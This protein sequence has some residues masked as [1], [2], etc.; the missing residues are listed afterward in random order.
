MAGILGVTGISD[1]MALEQ[2]NQAT[3][4]GGEM[5]RNTFLKLLTTQLQNQDPTSPMDNQEFVAQLAQ[6]TS[7]EQ[8][9]AMNG[10]MQSVVMGIASMNNATMASLVGTDVVAIGN[11][12]EYDGESKEVE[13]HFETAAKVTEGTITVYDEDGTMVYTADT[14]NLEAG[15]GSLTWDGI[16]TSGE[17]AEAGNYTFEITGTD[18]D[19]ENVEVAERIVGTISEM[20]YTSGAPR[21]SVDGYAFGIGDI[22]RLTAGSISDGS[23]D[24]DADGDKE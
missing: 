24:A 4:A 10:T 20:D 6:F 23:A 5:D 12:F 3:P 22:L 14:G 19:G 13:L 16:T 8:M 21:P 7:L 17:R 15:E 2:S 9:V 11:G 18:M 1:A